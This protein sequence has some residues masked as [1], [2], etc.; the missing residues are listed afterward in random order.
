MLIWAFYLIKQMGLNKD[1][2]LG[3]DVWNVVFLER[4]ISGVIGKQGQMVKK[5]LSYFIPSF[6]ELAR[7]KDMREGVCC[8]KW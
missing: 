7:R 3:V 4:L 5:K 2:Q 8:N 6:G 1:I